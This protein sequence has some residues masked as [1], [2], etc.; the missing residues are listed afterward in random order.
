MTEYSEPQEGH[1][2]EIPEGWE[3]MD[4]SKFE[5]KENFFDKWFPHGIGGY[6]ATYAITHPWVILSDWRREIK[7]AWQRVFRGWDDTVP[8]SV[9]HYLAKNIPLWLKKIKTNKCGTPMMMFK[10][11]DFSGE[12][13]E[14]PEDIAEIRRK[15]YEDILDKVILGFESYIENEN[16]YDVKKNEE[17]MEKF[18]EGMELF[19]KY[20]S[21]F[22]D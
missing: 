19:V 1:K 13:Y 3:E 14:I 15:E 18:N 11:T 2:I 16:C 4:I 17:L 7:Y 6:R 8:W 12:N 9:D 20:Y 5:T 21:T 22:W 10:D